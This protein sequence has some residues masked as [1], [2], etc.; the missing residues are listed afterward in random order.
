MYNLQSYQLK[1][2]AVL[3]ER[4]KKGTILMWGL[5]LLAA[6]GTADVFMSCLMTRR[7]P[8]AAVVT[9]ADLGFVFKMTPH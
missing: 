3:A 5:G 9:R 2:R 1:S 6:E 7:E 8:S 4:E